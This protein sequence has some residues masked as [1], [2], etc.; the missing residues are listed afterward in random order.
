MVPAFKVSLVNV[1]LLYEFLNRPGTCVYKVMNRMD[2]VCTHNAIVYDMMQAFKVNLVNQEMKAIYVPIVTWVSVLRE[3]QQGYSV[4]FTGHKQ[5][6]AYE[7]NVS[8]I[9]YRLFTFTANG[10]V[11]W[12]I[13]M[14]VYS[15]SLYIEGCQV[16]MYT[17]TLKDKH[18]T[19]VMH[20]DSLEMYSF[21]V[22]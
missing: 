16:H 3:M 4:K 18:T 15:I 17:G 19:T 12:T 5:Y 13:Y 9:K 6:V 21:A 2:T 7:K 20:W 11:L 14:H 22:R 1:I 10:N 8:T